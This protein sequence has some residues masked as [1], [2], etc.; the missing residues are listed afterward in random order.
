MDIKVEKVSNLT[1]KIT[2]TLPAEDVQPRLEAEYDTIR[3]DAKIKGFRRGKVP[4]KLII[5]TYK[6]QVEGEIGEKLVQETYFD[7]IEK[8]GVDP[9]THPE[10]QSVKYNEDGSFTYV[11]KIDLRP[12]FELAQYKGLEVE[13]QQ[14]LVT[15]EEV[16]LELIAMQKQNAV[17]SSVDR[18]V[19]EGDIVTIDFQGYENGEALDQVK[20]EG[21]TVDVG[22]G[23]MGEEF[24]SKLIGMKK[25]EEAEHEITFAEGH[26]NLLI[27]GKTIT[28]KVAVKDVK[29]RI[30]AELDDEFAKDMGEEFETLEELKSSI[31]SRRLKE[32]E[33]SAEG[34]LTD[35]LMQKLLE[36]HDFE[37]PNRLVAYEIDQMI[38]E[39]EEQ[40]EKSGM[41]L[42]AAG[43]SREKLAE[44]NVE[45]ATKRVKGDFILKKIAEVEN[46]KVTDEDLER[47]FKR[48]GDMYNMSVAQ[49]KE[50][51]KTRDD[52]LPFMNELLNEKILAFLRAEAVILEKE[53]ATTE[54]A[55]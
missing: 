31:R 2:I 4:R 38:K 30:L 34:Q 14:I 6:Q 27:K 43:L 40:L 23:S 51:F 44:E 5:K 22:A 55:E 21:Y 49:V 52:L 3:K 20:S 33:E 42:E 54:V 28:F 25:G 17:L 11:A 7:A 10:I 12:E 29:E 46:I 48:I 13:K 24:E 16:E 50:F 15:D 36:S 9:V 26:P 37:V 18:E 32:R 41:S 47:G 35:A 1:R 8:E 53:E 45:V 39:T 19:Q